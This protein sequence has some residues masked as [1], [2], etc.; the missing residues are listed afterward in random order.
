MALP[1]GRVW[2]RVADPEWSDPLESSYAQEHGGRWNPPGSFAT[3]YLNANLHT[4]RLQIARM[5]AGSPVDP[6]D[7]DDG[8][9]VLVAATLP[10]SQTCADAVSPAGLRALGLGDGYP[11][12]RR[13]SAVDHVTCQEVGLRVR[14]EGLRGVWC[15]SA[16]DADAR[17]RELAWF[18]ATA[19]SAARPVW[20]DP[21]PYGQ[22][23]DASDWD[24]IGLEDQPDPRP[25]PRPRRG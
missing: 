12:D 25:L 23:R 3:L 4:A 18:P 20:E 17:A 9:F 11:L 13:G 19:R 7:L 5:L 6:A 22:W 15:R 21:L 24:E 10:R 1:D 2:L 14:E 8:A 16:V